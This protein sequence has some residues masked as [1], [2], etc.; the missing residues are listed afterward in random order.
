VTQGKKLKKLVRAVKAELE[1]DTSLER[2]SYQW[3]RHMVEEYEG[4]VRGE[5]TPEEQIAKLVEMI[6]PH[7][8]KVK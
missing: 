7:A 5:G 4:A 2:P 6:R 1:Q 8:R 3:C